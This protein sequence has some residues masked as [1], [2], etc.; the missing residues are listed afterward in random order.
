MV[1]YL[2]SVLLLKSYEQ[3]YIFFKGIDLVVQVNSELVDQ[4][5]STTRTWTRKKN[6]FPT[7]GKGLQPSAHEC[8]WTLRR[9]LRN[10]YA[11]IL[12][13]PIN[14]KCQF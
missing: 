2:K 1:L 8:L 12:F 3:S 9:I 14:S 6:K 4:K 13:N 10:E 7:V 11:N 5:K